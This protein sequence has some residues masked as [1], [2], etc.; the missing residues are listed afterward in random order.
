MGGHELHLL[1][2]LFALQKSGGYQLFQNPG[3]GGRSSQALALGIVRHIV[4]PGSLHCG[5]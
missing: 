3:A 5:E 2:A 4:L 1:F